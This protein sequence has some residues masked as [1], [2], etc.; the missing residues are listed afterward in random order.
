MFS[1]SL[2]VV[3]VSIGR[4]FLHKLAGS[5]KINDL[6]TIVAGLYSMW[7]SIRLITITYNWIQIGI[8]QLYIKFKERIWIV[9]F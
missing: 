9:S 2:L 6:Y 8:Y 1:I 4:F 5:S 3:P 7:L